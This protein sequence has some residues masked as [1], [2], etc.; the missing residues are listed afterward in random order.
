MIPQR[1]PQLRDVIDTEM[2]VVTISPT[3]PERYDDA[4]VNPTRDGDSPDLELSD[5]QSSR[6]D[7]SLGTLEHNARKWGDTFPTA[8]QGKALSLCLRPLPKLWEPRG[9]GSGEPVHYSSAA[10]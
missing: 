3:C 7:R 1:N 2:Q 10:T 4:H 6:Q 5:P 9:M 8:A